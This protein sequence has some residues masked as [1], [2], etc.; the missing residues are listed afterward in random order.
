[1]RHEERLAQPLPPHSRSDAQG[2]E[3]VLLWRG[4]R[5]A[6]RHGRG[7]DRPAIRGHAHRRAPLCGRHQDAHA[8]RLV[9][10][11]DDPFRQIQ[12]FQPLRREMAKNGRG[13]IR[14][15][16]VLAFAGMTLALPHIRIGGQRFP[17][18]T[19]LGRLEQRRNVNLADL[20]GGGYRLGFR[21]ASIGRPA[22]GSSSKRPGMGDWRYRPASVPHRARHA[23]G[24][25]A[26]GSRWAPASHVSAQA[27]GTTR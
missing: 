14:A 4:G 2:Q 20:P 12:T 17:P 19:F 18:T 21:R 15:G 24:I 9:Q 3:L 1:M 6:G 23:E 22:F 10:G 27:R 13:W 11:R 7:D 8:G 26:G 5:G 25:R 16:M